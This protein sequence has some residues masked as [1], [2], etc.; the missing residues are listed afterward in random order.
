[1]V[2]RRDAPSIPRYNRQPD[3]QNYPTVTVVMP[4][5]NEARLIERSLGAVLNQD[6][7]AAKLEII[8]A[9]GM[10][11]D[12]TV[13]RIRQLASAQRIRIVSNKAIIQSAGLNHAIK[14]ATGEIIVRVDGHTI[15][16][17]D[18]IRRC[19]EVICSTKAQAVG[20]RLYPAGYSAMGKAIARA[21]STAFAIPSAFRVTGQSGYV[22]TVYMGAWRR[23]TL[24]QAGLFNEQLIAN[25][26]YEL[27][28]RLRAQGGK[29]YLSQTISSTYYGSETLTELARQYL[30]YGYW[31]SI[32]LRLHPKSLRLRH[33]AAPALWI[34]L[35]V[36]LGLILFEPHRPAYM[37]IGVLL[38]VL[39]TAVCW[40]IVGWEDRSLLWRMPLVYPVMHLSWG[41]GFWWG[42]LSSMRKILP[43]SQS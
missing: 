34:Y 2:I 28:Y 35:L 15:I 23:S 33:L 42:I 3:A 10:S 14:L 6:Y 13:E 39:M 26:D 1:M 18:Y 41:A 24:M 22:D 31:K 19:V 12:E 38:Y 5:R 36:G 17:S 20:G 27:N 43:S 4:V 29:I 9:D 40:I 8:V 30:R 11:T 25:E 21:G 32:M 16:A 7:P 37:L